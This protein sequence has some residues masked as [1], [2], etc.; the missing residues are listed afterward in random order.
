[1]TRRASSWIGKEILR[2]ENLDMFANSKHI[3]FD[4]RLGTT[5]EKAQEIAI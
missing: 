1:M 4:L 2:S 5:Q 3:G